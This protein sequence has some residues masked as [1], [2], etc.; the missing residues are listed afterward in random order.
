[1]VDKKK[2]GLIKQKPAHIQIKDPN[3][4]RSPVYRYPE[5]AKK[6]IRQILKDLADGDIIERSTSAWLS[7]IVL[8][9]KPNGEKRMF[10]LQKG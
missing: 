3:P 5:K 1:M 6:T 7:P 10:R 8:V 2:L 9:N 4:C